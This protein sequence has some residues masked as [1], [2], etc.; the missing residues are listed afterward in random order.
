MT[1]PDYLTLKEAAERS[2]LSVSTLRNQIKNERI[3]KIMLG[4]DYLIT[5]AALDAYL[6]SRPDD[7]RRKDQPDD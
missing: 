5:P 4:R 2:G 7:R 3:P 1:N 6:E